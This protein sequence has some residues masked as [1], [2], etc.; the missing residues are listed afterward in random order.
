MVYRQLSEALNII[1]NRIKRFSKINNLIVKKGRKKYIHIT[2]VGISSNNKLEP[3]Q[4]QIIREINNSNFNDE[5]SI[6]KTSS[7]EFNFNNISVELLPKTLLKQDNV[8]LRLDIVITW[9]L[10]V[11][12]IVISLYALHATNKQNEIA[13][14]ANMPIFNLQT[15]ISTDNKEIFYYINNSGGNI[16]EAYIRVYPTLNIKLHSD[17]NHLSDPFEYDVA[18][19]NYNSED[20]SKYDGDQKCFKLT[21]NDEKYKKMSEY[22]ENTKYKLWMI[23]NDNNYYLPVVSVILYINIVYSDYRG[24]KNE[25]WYAINT[26]NNFRDFYIVDS[27]KSEKIANYEYD[28]VIW[29]PDF[30]TGKQRSFIR[31][32]DLNMEDLNQSINMDTLIED[33]LAKYEKSK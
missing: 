20:F 25:E 13:D 12:A 16:N 33:I 26:M 1:G 4:V 9:A 7:E 21:I 28:N 2:K 10:S 8:L 30:R 14:K 6:S 18:L 24:I 15:D 22:S 5:I 3:E 19:S 29:A 27:K 31:Y 23:S 17:E 32:F 11:I